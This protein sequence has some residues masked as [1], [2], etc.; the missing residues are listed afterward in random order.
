MTHCEIE[1]I[2]FEKLGKMKTLSMRVCVCELV[3]VV[4]V[5]PLPGWESQADYRTLRAFGGPR[6]KAQTR[7][8]PKTRAARRASAN[9]W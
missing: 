1:D 6:P 7:I 2:E 3:V 9:P 5:G 8:W 4:V